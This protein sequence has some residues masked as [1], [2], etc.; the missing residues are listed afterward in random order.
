LRDGK[1]LD[2]HPPFLIRLPLKAK[3]WLPTMPHSGKP[4]LLVV[5][6]DEFILDLLVG[7]LSPD[8]EVHAFSNPLKAVQW[9]NEL[10]PIDGLI[11][12]LEM[13]ELFGDD[14]IEMSRS[15]SPDL[16]VI[17][18]TGRPDS[19][20]LSKFQTDGKILIL[21]KPINLGE[22]EKAVKTHLL[23]SLESPGS[24]LSRTP[25]GL[26]SIRSTQNGA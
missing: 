22:F 17:V 24:P 1:C 4:N 18:M 10:K 21:A 8:C 20:S 12:D 9:F 15:Y 25:G 7:V 23:G 13:P 26:I 2:A 3:N 5:D 6:D 11:T 16:K 19:P 14:L